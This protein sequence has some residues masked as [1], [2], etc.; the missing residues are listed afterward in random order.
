MCVFHCLLAQRK[1][2][3]GLGF[4]EIS[5][6]AEKRFGGPRRQGH[7]GVGDLANLA[8]VIVWRRGLLQQTSLRGN[9]FEHAGFLALNHWTFLAY[10]RFST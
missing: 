8:K 1:L 9:Y 7:W 5:Y 10:K 2:T 4:V 6:G 3:V